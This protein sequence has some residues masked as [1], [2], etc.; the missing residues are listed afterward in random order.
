MT[1]GSFQILPHPTDSPQQYFYYQIKLVATDRCGRQ[2][3]DTIS[4]VLPS[5]YGP[6]GLNG[7]SI[8]GRLVDLFSSPSMFESAS[9][10]SVF[11]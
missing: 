6:A 10:H 8:C 7:M 5:T 2:D 11:L 3:W 1:R 9:T 4:V